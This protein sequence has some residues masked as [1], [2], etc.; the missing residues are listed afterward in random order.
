M[1]RDPDIVQFEREFKAIKE[2]QKKING[3]VHDFSLLNKEIKQLAF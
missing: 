3:Y 2:N 1:V